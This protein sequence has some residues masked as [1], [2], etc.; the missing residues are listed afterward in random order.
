M[1]GYPSGDLGAKLEL[2]LGGAWTDITGYALPDGTQDVAISV[3]SQDGSQGAQSSTTGMTW[4]NGDGRFTSDNPLSPY[5]GQLQQNT[6]ARISVASPYGSYLRLEAGNQDR[7]YVNENSRLDIT[8]SLEARIQLRLTDWRPMIFAAKWDTGG[9]WW[10]GIGDSGMFFSWWDSA[11][12]NHTVYATASL[13]ATTAATAYRVTM[14]AA[15][16]AVT[17][18]A[19]SSI[20]GTWTQLGSVVSATGAT[21]IK[22]AGSPLVVGWSANFTGQMCGEVDEFRLYNGIGGTV[23]ADAKFNALAAGTTSWTDAQ[24]N[25]WSLAGGAEISDRDYRLHGEVSALNTS[26]DV[27]GGNAQAAV[28]VAGPLRRLQQGDAPP[29]DSA[30][31]RAILR[32]T[33]TLYP[34]AYWPME[35]MAQAV[36]LASALGGPPLMI[37][38]AAELAS[39]SSFPCSSPLPQTNGALFRG[40]V[41]PY[42]P[43]G[44]I[45]FR[46]LMKLGDTPPTQSGW[47]LVR[48][49]T[50]GTCPY[51]DFKI[52]PDY[53]IGLSGSGGPTAVFDTGSVLINGL[54]AGTMKDQLC[55]ASVELR[56]AG[57]TGTINWAFVLLFPGATAAQDLN[58]TFQ[59]TAGQVTQV[60]INGAQLPDTV[61]GHAS[62]Q[63]AWTSMFDLQGPLEAWQ[64][65]LAGQRFT[66]LLTEE[67]VPARIIGPPAGTLAMGPQPVDT[68]MNLL[69]SCADTEQGY[70]YEPPGALAIGFRAYSGLVNQQPAVTFTPVQ[71]TA[72]PQANADDQQLVNDWTVSN[73][74]TSARASLETGGQNAVD[75]A[76]RY[77]DSAQANPA[78]LEGLADVA[79]WKLNVSTAA[80]ARYPQLAAAYGNP[81]VTAAQVSA[82]ARMLPGDRVRVTGVPAQS[83][84]P[85]I[86]QLALGWTETLGPGRAVT[87]NCTAEEP[88]RTA[89]LGAESGRAD[90]DGSTLAAAVTAA[91]TTLSVA[92]VN[93]FPIWTTATADFPLDIRVGGER[94]TVTKIAGSSSPQTFTVIRAVNGIS[95]AQAAGADVRLWV[96]PRLALT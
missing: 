82:M 28:T 85:E 64:G 22:A 30:M 31:K 53:T 11:G 91:A 47:P 49:V 16:G 65:E 46:F 10:W 74:T 4:D 35:D 19:G 36:S 76:G 15:T 26:S 70:I 78:T 13:P 84:A 95:K 56:P 71:M 58:G 18:Y 69:Q 93:G 25:A 86:S 48:L 73:G 9:C 17:F 3:A 52:Y 87:W 83:G 27:S 39:D 21:S 81:D 57:M 1:T 59:G 60:V 51:I 55:W 32:Q 63:S 20:D 50:N 2:Q 6:P 29:L 80:G 5:Y 37:S 54:P 68:L 90:T 44:T 43:T 12:A 45:V 23:A 62:L 89:V 94:M 40:R 77:Q 67:G 34:V 88:W 14:N 79:G 8:G 24:G 7:A 66:R 75:K 92:T 72:A 96:T 38:G 61:I 33:G 42:V 41:V